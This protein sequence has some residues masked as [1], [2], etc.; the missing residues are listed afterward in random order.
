[1]PDAFPHHVKF[2]T[3]CRH[4]EKRHIGNDQPAI[5][6]ASAFVPEKD[7]VFGK[8]IVKTVRKNGRR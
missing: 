4:A 2:A 7:C 5:F 3:A 8:M 6:V 1:M